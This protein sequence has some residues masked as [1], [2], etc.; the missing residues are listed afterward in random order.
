MEQK[1]EF[2]KRL[3]EVHKENIGTPALCDKPG[4]CRITEDWEIVLPQNPSR[5]M[6]YLG[7]D[8]RDFFETSLGMALRV[9]YEDNCNRV[10]T[11]RFL[12][13]HTMEADNGLA[14]RV[15]VIGDSITIWGKTER[16]TA[17][18]S[19]LL[20]DEMRIQAASLVPLME[21]TVKPM[22][23]PRMT[24]S[25]YGMDTF[26]DAYMAQAAHAGM[27]A[28]LV[29][30]SGLYKNHC[31]FPDPDALWEGTC[32]GFCDFNELVYRAAGFGLD[33]YVYSHYICDMHPSEPGAR[34]Y[35]DERFGAFFRE[36]PGV[37]GIIFVGE[38]FEFP[39]RDPHT[40]G[41][42]Y[43]LRTPEDK[44]CNVGWYPCTDYPELV[45]MVRDVIREKAPAADVV[46]WSYNWGYQPV[47]E[48]LRLIRDLPRDISL[49]VTYDMF[50]QFYAPEED[51]TYG[52]ADYSISFTGPGQYFVTEAE[53]AK[54]L[55][56]R[57][58]AMTNTGGRTWDMGLVPYLPF[59]DQWAAR[60]EKL[61][62]SH[63]Q[64][65]L[66]GL[67]ESHHFGWVPS[68]ISDLMKF[69]YASHGAGMADYIDTLAARDFGSAA[70]FARSAWRDFSEAI[71]CIVPSGL[72]QYGPF[73]IGP[74][75]PLVF[76]QT[77][78]EMPKVPY[79]QHSGNAICFPLYRQDVLGNP[80]EALLT[81]HRTQNAVTL[82]S[83]GNAKLAE[84]LT[85]LSG[86][87]REEGNR[88]L[89]LC[90]FM[91]NTYRTAVHV[92][93]WNMMKALLPICKDGR[94]S[95]Y[96]A[97]VA[98]VLPYVAGAADAGDLTVPKLR[99][100]MVQIAKAEMDN[101]VATIPLCET[102]SLLGY[103][104]SMEYMC[105][106]EHIQWKVNVVQ[107]SMKRLLAEW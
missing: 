30:T 23:S 97:L 6:R 70:H 54:R 59:P 5:L 12:T 35:Y 45:T 10:H 57:L 64:Y 98:E 100:G 34:E 50:E 94:L 19:Y 79:G 90:R 107:E 65:G 80:K 92:K 88:F 41:K 68:F 87:R 83:R 52:I 63:D 1:Y 38:T 11:I 36:F 17:Q 46:F 60:C 29:Y 40:I 56:I 55:G 71:R 81:L 27:D 44:G 82:L 101:A 72:D 7:H 86:T 95:E 8:L 74:T 76:D 31:G 20:E 73:R 24:H 104:P 48:R 18:G 37:K 33:V 51:T 91:E 26:P 32:Q 69:G 103:E 66:C 89:A 105:S 49:L 3:L 14:Y 106:A 75:Y 28:I 22:F 67:M 15:S 13:D 21:K 47:E 2:R 4:Y 39:S 93:L 77:D 62:D 25:G 61:A 96:A 99:D 43:Q 16:G 53:E 85:M 58:Y 102:D 9:R 78:V 42:R 84:G